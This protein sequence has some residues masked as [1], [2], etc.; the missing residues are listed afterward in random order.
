MSQRVLLVDDVND[1]GDTLEVAV[2]HLQTFQP[3]DIRTAVIHDKTS[4]AFSV[5]YHG[6]KI[7][8]WRW[9]IYPW[10]VCED[11]TEFLKRLSPQPQTLAEAQRQLAGHYGIT[12][13]ERRLKTIVSFMD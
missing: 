10:A 9:L 6:R 1:S 4:T 12:I 13:P 2:Q 11:V 8:K 3:A 7:V 5:D